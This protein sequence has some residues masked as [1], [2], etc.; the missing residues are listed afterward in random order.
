MSARSSRDRLTPPLRGLP[1]FVRHFVVAAAGVAIGGFLFAWSGLFNVAASRGHFAAVELALSFIMRNSVETH[2]LAVPAPPPLDNPDLTILGAGYF[3]RG[4]APCHGAPGQQPNAASRAMLPTP[5]DVTDTSTRWSDRELF[6]IVKHGIKYTGMPAWTS[7][8]R[9]DEVWALVAFLKQLPDL[10]ARRYETLA[11]G[12]D[13][14]PLRD[15]IIA[16]CAAC[17]GDADRAPRSRLVPVLHGQPAAFLQSALQAYANGIRHSGIMQ[18]I[19]TDLSDRAIASVAA[20][21]ARLAPPSRPAPSASVESAERGRRLVAEGRPADAIPPCASCH[22]GNALETFPRLAGQN[23]AYMAARLRLLKNGIDAN[24]DAA[25][26]MTP[27]A[28]ALSDR[29]IEDA[30]A[31]Y[32]ALAPARWRP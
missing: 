21:Y 27:I 24:S 22:G 20:Y 30:S 6:F 16:G 18:P 15:T 11:L 3:Q 1:P 9:D 26:V 2:A 25:A 17:H 19:A 29:D 12:A 13:P 10:D 23:A 31:Y 32:S 5:P 4:C 28:R 14:D 8:D 7:Q